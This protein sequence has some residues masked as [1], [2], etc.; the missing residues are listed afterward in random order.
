MFIDILIVSSS[1]NGDDV[2]F[3]DEFSH[4]IRFTAKLQELSCIDGISDDISSE[5]SENDGRSEGNVCC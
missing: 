1:L 5:G 3:A 4:E 2:V